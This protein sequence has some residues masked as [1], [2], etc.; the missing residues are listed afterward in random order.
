MNQTDTGVL[1]SGAGVAGLALA[2]WLRRFGFRPTVVEHAPRLRTGGYGIDL[3]GA[4]VDVAERMGLLDTV[5]AAR[6]RMRGIAYVDAAGAT[7]VELS[8][9]VFAGAGRDRDVEIPRGDLLEILHRATADGTE[10]LFG[11]SVAALTEGADGVEVAFERGGT[12]RFG[13]VVGADGMHSRVRAL[14]FGPETRYRHHLGYYISICT[15]P[16]RLGREHWTLLHNEPGRLVGTARAASGAP[17]HAVFGFASPE[18]PGDRDPAVQR[19]ALADA[20]AGVG[21]RAPEL[22]A[23]MEHA[24]DFYFDSISQIRLDRWSRGRIALVGD[25]GYCASPLSGQGTSLA[26]VGAYVLAGELAAAGG[27]H[28]AAFA[29][30]Q[31]RMAGFVARNQKVALSG[32][33]TLAPRTRAA[34]WLRD[35][36]IRLLPHLPR[37]NGLAS[38]LDRASTAIELPDYAPTGRAVG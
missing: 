34:L 4:A 23:E 10:Y 12:R 17:T 24:P 33:G 19:R 14:A 15:V 29:R 18:L 7:K 26:L 20:F 9:D 16:D 28:A 30:Y 36:T 8:A 32:A 13:L 37:L 2:Y 21:W 27:D 3:R 31:E 11:D 5:R 25:A 35:R 38:A 22:L 1:V 6:T